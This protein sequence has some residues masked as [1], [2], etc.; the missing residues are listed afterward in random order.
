MLVTFFNL[1]NRSSTSQSLRLK[2]TTHTFRRQHPSP[3]RKI[4]SECINNT[5]VKGAQTVSVLL[6]TL[7]W[8][9]QGNSRRSDFDLARASSQR[10]AVLQGTLPILCRAPSVDIIH[11]IYFS[12]VLDARVSIVTVSKLV[13]VSVTGNCVCPSGSSGNFESIEKSRNVSTN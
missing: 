1:I 13:D 10:G 4:G 5:C 2:P 3:T 9:H 11:N 12:I 7:V 8:C 6:V